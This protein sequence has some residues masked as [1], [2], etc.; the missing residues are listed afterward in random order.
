MRFYFGRYTGLLQ[1]GNP[2]EEEKKRNVDDSWSEKRKKKCC[3]C[4]DEG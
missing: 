4:E 2:P 3:K 1:F